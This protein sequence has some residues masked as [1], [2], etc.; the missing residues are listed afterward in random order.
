MQ[1]PFQCAYSNLNPVYLYNLIS[2][3]FL[4]DLSDS[5]TIQF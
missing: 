2:F 5:V 4:S 3:Q 1:S